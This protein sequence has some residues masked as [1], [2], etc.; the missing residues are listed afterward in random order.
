MDTSNLLKKLDIGFEANQRLLKL[1]AEIDRYR[2]E[3]TALEG[4][5]TRGLKELRR[6]STPC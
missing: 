5:E 1:I 2:G 3:W 6:I 4:T